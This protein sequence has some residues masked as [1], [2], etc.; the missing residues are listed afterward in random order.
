MNVEEC[1]HERLEAIDHPDHTKAKCLDCEAIQYRF[2]DLGALYVTPHS[3]AMI[4]RGIQYRHTAFG[5]RPLPT[6]LPAVPYVV[7]A[8]EEFK[9]PVEE[10]RS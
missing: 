3:A 8:A 5:W 6:D 2:R 9:Q 1:D 10:E 7:R 4:H